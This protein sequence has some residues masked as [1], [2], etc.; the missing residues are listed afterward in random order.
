MK[1]KIQKQ[2][3]LSAI[4]A[5]FTVVSSSAAALQVLQLNL[6]QLYSLSDRVF[7]GTCKAVTKT[8]DNKGRHIYRVTIKVSKNGILKGKKGESVTFNQIRSPSVSDSGSIGINHLTSNLPS[9]EVGKEMI[10][11]LSG[12]SSIGLSSPIGLDQGKFMVKTNSNNQKVVLN[13]M[14]NRGLFI[15]LRNSAS[16]KAASLST[17]EQKLMNKNGGEIAL[18]SFVS[19]VKKLGNK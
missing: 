2:L 16:L 6:L 14:G 13:N 4:V 12:V 1:M 5:I 9:Y 3:I 17:G 10:I 18:D 7:L 8:R 19:L 15:G 11:F